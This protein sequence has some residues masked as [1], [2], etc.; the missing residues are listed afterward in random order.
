M[1]CS[2]MFEL[3]TIEKEINGTKYKFRPLFGRHLAP[4][5]AVLE[6]LTSIKGEGKESEDV[7]NTDLFKALDEET[8]KKLHELAYQTMIKC[9]PEQDKIVLDEFVSQNLIHFIEPIVSVNM[10]SS[11][12]K[13]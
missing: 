7:N 10:P 6:K 4:F 9:Y 12:T 5:Y 3:K 2:E 11:E 13:A 8:V 1:R